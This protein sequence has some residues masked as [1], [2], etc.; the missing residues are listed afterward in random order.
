MPM[1]IEPDRAGAGYTDE[2]PLKGKA[3]R[4]GILFS[5]LTDVAPSR[6]EVNVTDSLDSPQSHSDDQAFVSKRPVQKL[7]PN[8]VVEKQG[9][10]GV[11]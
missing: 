4:S 6:F 1:R 10:F 9:L 3:A 5:I 8:R 7:E 11:R 2:D